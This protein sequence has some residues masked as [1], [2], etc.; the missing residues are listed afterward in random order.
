[1]ASL[2]EDS[3]SDRRTAPASA[4]RGPQTA[5]VR[6]GSIGISAFMLLPS[7][8]SRRNEDQQLAAGVG[9]RVALEQPLEGRHP[10]QD[11]RAA[12]R[13]LLLADEDAAEDRRRAGVDLGES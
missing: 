13:G 3:T 2:H 8:N 11:R 1:M 4:I 9:Q 6:T 10:V 12:V 7:Q 5:F